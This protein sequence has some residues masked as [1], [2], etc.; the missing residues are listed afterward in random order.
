MRLDVLV[1]CLAKPYDG[2]RVPGSPG[3]VAREQ[4]VSN[5]R[6]VPA[7]FPPAQAIPRRDDLLNESE[8]IALQ[9]LHAHHITP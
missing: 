2:I 8:A 5:R 1:A 4:V 9:R 7:F 3:T 6:G